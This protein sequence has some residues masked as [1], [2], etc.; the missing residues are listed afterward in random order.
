MR[1]TATKDLHILSESLVERE[2]EAPSP[3]ATGLQ[4]FPH[5]KQSLCIKQKNHLLK[6]NF[7]ENLIRL[8]MILAYQQLLR[9]LLNR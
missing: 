3:V 6:T 7:R 9:E 5:F 1:E 8:L 2:S 4:R